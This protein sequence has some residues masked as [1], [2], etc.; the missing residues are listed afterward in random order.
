MKQIDDFILDYDLI[1]KVDEEILL[2][3]K[4]LPI[5]EEEI[6]ILVAC[7]DKIEDT[8]ILKEFF[9]KPIKFF[10]IS[11]NI[12]EYEFKYKKEKYEIY[13]LA[14]QSLLLSDQDD[15]NISSISKFTQK[16]FKL[17]ISLNCSDIHIETLNESLIIRFR[18]DGILIQF[19]K[20]EYALY[21]ILSSSIKLF[22]SLDISQKRLPQN[23]RFSRKINNDDFDFRVSILPTISGES[24]VIRILDNKKAFVKLEDIGFSSDVYEQISKNI[25][26]TQGMILITGPTGSGKT[27]TLYSILNKLNNQNLK[28]I[29]LEDPV[30]YNINGITQVSINYDLGLTYELGLKNILRQDPDIIMIGEIRDEKT[31]HVA[32]QAA[33]TGHLVIA[34]LHTNDAIKTINRLLDLKAEPFLIA[35]VLKL[36]VSQRLIR[37]LCENCKQEN[38]MDGIKVY[39]AKGCSKCNLTGYT[40]RTIVTE[41]LEID[42]KISQMISSKIDIHDISSYTSYTTIN[43]NSY[44]KVLE[45]IT[46]LQEYYRNEI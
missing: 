29:T 32:I 46:S 5:K 26:F 43:D 35:S 36:I 7:V 27:T 31:L 11:Y 28:I 3:Y 9:D 13:S 4:I 44:K 16:L 22:A 45:G 12:F 10:Q 14:K 41:S 6:Y 33:L 21:Y 2:K 30:E 40:N 8:T 34:T 1:N 24:I 18:I 17:A 15:I 19:F 42:E 39:E 25:H 20:F 23:G 38:F 37:V